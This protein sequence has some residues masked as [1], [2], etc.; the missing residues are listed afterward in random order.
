MTLSLL[1]VSDFNL[2]PL[3]RILTHGEDRPSVRAE[4]APFGQVVQTLLDPRGDA[5]GF[6]VV[7]TRAEGVLDA[8]AST[9]DGEPTDETRV[10]GE[11]D[12]FAEQ[13][14][15]FATRRRHVYVASWVAPPGSRG[16]GPLDWRP[17][18][19][20]AYLLAKMNQRLAERLAAAPNIHL[21]DAERWVRAAG[22]RASTTKLWLATKVA[23]ATPTLMEAA[24]DIKA[25]LLGLAGESRR[26][27]VVDLDDTLWGGI[28]GDV[29]A[30]GLTLGGHDVAGEAFIEFQ[31]ALKALTRRGVQLAVAS[32]NDETVALDAIDTHPEMLLRR[33]D[34]AG[35]RINWSDKAQN[36]V[37]LARELNLGLASIVFLDDSPAERARVREALPDVLVP[38]WPADPSGYLDALRAL[39]C[40]D[41][42]TLTTEDRART[43]MYVAERGRR[44][45]QTKVSS[46]D[47][48]VAQLGIRLTVAP[49]DDVTLS[50]AAQLLNKTNQLN[51]STRRMSETE[52]LAWSHGP[53]RE[54]F[55]VSVE[56]RFGSSGLTGLIGLE[57]EGSRLRI[58][59]FV[60]SC[61]V[62]GRKIEE[63]L[64]H[65][66]VERARALGA[67]EVLAR[68]L[69]TKRNGPC[70]AFWSS[71]SFE[72]R[73]G[74]ELAWNAEAPYPAP[75]GITIVGPGPAEGAR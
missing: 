32:K 14:L 71:T 20:V 5:E 45:A 43:E 48:W 6:A 23:Y 58:V 39:R 30:E 57:L 27:V 10:L 24:A 38:E 4:A 12:A 62:M 60:L 72:R 31:R 11:V 40:F 75:K 73:D 59:D 15:A 42:A 53:G 37:D 46:L 61:R 41:S 70:L 29:G 69:P 63:A 17:G 51:L 65:L 19:G 44:D 13:L 54:L 36:I 21:L 66:A 1:L 9:V 16:Y 50:R 28:L 3:A 35:W 2:E 56:D 34:F 25:A 33:A 7:W 47:D 8:F 68:H 55:T 64:V 26:L 22:P 67:N 52:L 74:G 18:V 49:L